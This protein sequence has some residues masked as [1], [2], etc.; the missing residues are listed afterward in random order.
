MG[1]RRTLW[2]A[3]DKGNE[4]GLSDKTWSIVRSKQTLHL[5]I[6][7]MELDGFAHHL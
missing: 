5:G 1:E 2:K 4:I 6:G 7:R 3:N